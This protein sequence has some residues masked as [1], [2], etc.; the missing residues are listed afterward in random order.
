MIDNVIGV[1]DIPGAKN[2]VIIAFHGDLLSSSIKKISDIF[3]QIVKNE[4]FFAIADMSAVTSISSA[5]LGEYLG[6]RKR[7][8]EKGGDLVFAAIHREL[9]TKLSLMGANKIFNFFNDTRSAINN[10]RWRVEKKP[11]E[12]NLSF[13]PYLKLVPPI[14]QLISRIA[15]HK[16]YSNRDSFRIETIIDEVCNNAVEH[17]LKDSNQEI[18]LTVKIDPEKIEIVVTNV[19][20]PGKLDSLQTLLR[21]AKTPENNGKSDEKRGRG[22]ALIKMLSTELSVNCS[23]TGT[24]VHVK[25]LRE[26]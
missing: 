9:R 7:L 12:L 3:D 6:G 22:L 2:A 17:G 23:E 16:G 11:E 18:T 26:E 15:K 4:K 25:K 13:P 14:R 10:Y 8:I 1:T 20:D 5:A 19:S 21:P 24:T